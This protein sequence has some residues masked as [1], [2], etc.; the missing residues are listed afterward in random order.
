MAI[1]LEKDSHKHLIGSIKQYFLEELEQNIGDLKAALILSFILKEIGPFIYNHAVQD[2]QARM[3]E[4]VSE[5]DGI[6]FES[7]SSYPRS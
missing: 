6:C 1:E 4:F 2:V 3:L 5:L 7:E